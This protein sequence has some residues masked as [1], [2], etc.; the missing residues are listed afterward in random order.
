MR[1]AR[2]E[3]RRFI[4][5]ERAATQPVLADFETTLSHIQQK[6]HDEF[7]RNADRK[8]ALIEEVKQ[9]VNSEDSRKAIDGVKQL[10]ARWQA[11][12]ASARKTEQQLWREFRDG[13]DAVFAKRQQQSAEFKTELEANLTVAKNLVIELDKLSE[14]S[15]SDLTE[16]RKR[17]DEI[18]QEFG[19]LGQFP[20]AQVTDIKTAFTQAVERFEQKLKDERVALK[21]QVW[22]NL[23]AANNMV[24]LHELALV[25]GK[26]A[27]D[28]KLQSEID[29]IAQWPNGGLKS[30]QQKISRVNAGADIKENL[31]AL[32][33]LSIRAEILTDSL[34]P[35][36][37]Q[38]LR[39]SF[40]VNQLQQNFGRKATDVA[41]E[42]EH[43]IFD[44]VAIGA[45]ETSEYDA[46]FKRFNAC[47]LKVAN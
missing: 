44:W 26:P 25:K 7:A 39:M 2:Q 21:Q 40:Q 24:R 16:A 27:D 22:V 6:L 34:T 8:K 32:R 38:S 28:A 29:D 30:I 36:E 43:L 41:A 1:V 37:D 14:L 20:K 11:I 3:W 5:T 42:F 19:G 12:G 47:R 9:L 4:P 17:V 45:V 33:E 46:L 18:R 10:Q 31:A 15:G 23:F 35:A 13:C